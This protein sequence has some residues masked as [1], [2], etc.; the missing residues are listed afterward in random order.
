[1][2]KADIFEVEKRMR[3]LVATINGFDDLR[4]SQRA[5]DF[6]YVKTLQYLGHVVAAGYEL[7]ELVLVNLEHWCPELPEKHSPW[8]WIKADAYVIQ[9]SM[10]LELHGLQLQNYTRSTHLAE[11]INDE[12]TKRANSHEE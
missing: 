6:T 11:N 5:K 10:L 9:S 7:A 3:T 8:G 1:M 2:L 4:Q 12:L